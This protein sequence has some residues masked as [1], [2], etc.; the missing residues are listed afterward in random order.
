[1]I[2]RVIYRK[3]V[4]L[5]LAGSVTGLLFFG[6][7]MLKNRV[8]KQMYVA[9]QGEI[10]E[11]FGK[12]CGWMISEKVTE[13]DPDGRDIEAASPLASGDGTTSPKAGEA[14]DICGSLDRFGESYKV[15]YFLFGKIPLAAANVSVVSRASVYAGGMP[16]GIYMETDGVMVV[17]TDH[18]TAVDG[19]EYAPA[20]N[21]L[22]S[23]DYIKAADGVALENKEELIDCFNHCGGSDVVLDVTRNGE[24]IRLKVTPVQTGEHD[25]KAGIWVRNDTQG[26]G[27]LTY[28]EDSGRYGA[29]GHG[30]SDVDTGKLLQIKEGVLYDTDVISIV[31]GTQGSP[32]ELAGVIHYSDGYA[33]GTIEKNQENGIY[34]QI[35]GFPYFAENM[36]KY[37]TAYRH[38]VESGGASI[39]CTVDGECR[40]Y[41]IEIEEIR[42]N[43][44]DIN[45]GMVIRVTDEELLGLTGGIVQGMS[46][47][48]I[49]QNGRIVGAVTHV[50][51]N[52]PTKGYGI[53]IENMLGQ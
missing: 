45:K 30:I 43:G 3:I 21:I 25:Y 29:L 28:V 37:E 2:N 44:K 40:E 32:G 15:E 52:D 12:T 9:E 13:L 7:L 41:G 18:V 22:K 27:T 23:G 5:M 16:I 46:G 10:P 33:V 51:V 4:L 49:I 19:E 20:A 31:R 35:A 48:P 1:M 8:P 53:F 24:D 6:W 34:G 11:L 50:F 17:D 36:K 26:I 42:I 39:L 14:Q 38:E 47:S